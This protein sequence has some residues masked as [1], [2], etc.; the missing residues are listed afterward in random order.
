MGTSPILSS[1]VSLEGSGHCTVEIRSVSNREWK[2]RR[3]AMRSRRWREGNALQG[4]NMWGRSGGAG[5][6]RVTRTQHRGGRED[7]REGDALRGGILE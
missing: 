6:E 1:T 3:V 4:G 2:G 5:T 7:G